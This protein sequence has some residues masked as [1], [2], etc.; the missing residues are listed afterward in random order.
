M[1]GLWSRKAPV[2]AGGCVREL[3]AAS[4]SPVGPAQP[5]KDLVAFD[6]WRLGF[7]FHA[8]GCV[9]S[10]CGVLRPN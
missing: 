3:S 1:G 9:A 10:A 5:V 6:K 4:Q 2:S 8:N 7:K